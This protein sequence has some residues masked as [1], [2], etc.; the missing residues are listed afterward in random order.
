MVYVSSLVFVFIFICSVCINWR[1][2]NSNVP[3]K[4]VPKESYGF[5]YSF[6]GKWELKYPSRCT[7]HTRLN[8]F[9]RNHCFIY[10]S[11][12]VIPMFQAS[13]EYTSI[14]NLPFAV[15]Y[16]FP[17]HYRLTRDNIYTITVINSRIL[18]NFILFNISYVRCGIGSTI[19][20]PVYFFSVFFITVI[21]K[22]K[23]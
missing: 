2:R 12:S 18:V 16:S 7:S 11:L 3:G 14:I 23:I 8:A 1:E 19:R 17:F 6:E 13:S 21:M 20:C 5:N 22:F 10:V 15:L 4:K 9:L